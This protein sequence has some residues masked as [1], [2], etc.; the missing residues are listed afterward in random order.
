MRDDFN[1]SIN[2]IFF[3]EILKEKILLGKK[4]LKIILEFED[5]FSQNNIVNLISQKSNKINDYIEEYIEFHNDII[6][7][8]EFLYN[9]NIPIKSLAFS[10]FHDMSYFCIDYKNDT[11]EY[12]S[13]QTDEEKNILINY[14]LKKGEIIN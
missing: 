5:D 12:K 6:K 10:G 14:K 3:I 1:L 4:Q 8:L 2:H 9:C 11:I 13:N 7:K